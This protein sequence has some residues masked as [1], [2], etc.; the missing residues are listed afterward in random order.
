MIK[1]N[2]DNAHSE[3]GFKVKHLVISTVRGKFTAFEGSITGEDEDLTKSNIT[4]SADTESIN[5]NNEMRDNHLRSAE[6]FDTAKFPKLSFKSKSI[7]KK[8]DT[9]FTVIGDL[10][11]RGVTKEI[12]LNAVFNGATIDHYGGHVK[13]FDIIGNLSREAFGLTWNATLETGGFAVS[14]EVKLDIIAEFKEA[15]E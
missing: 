11:M 15:K 7:S 12:T 3:I 14:D 4:F 9:E 10:T 13:S 1:W 6:F 5:T 8:N 2:I